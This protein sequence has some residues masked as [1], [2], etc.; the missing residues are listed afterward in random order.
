[1][2]RIA[3]ISTLL[4]L[5]L[6]GIWLLARPGQP[7]PETGGRQ[8]NLRRAFGPVASTGESGARQQP[9][10]PPPAFEPAEPVLVDFRAAPDPEA[11][12]FDSQYDLWLRGEIDLDREVSRISEVEM[13]ERR[14]ASLARRPDAGVQ[15]SSSA[16][17]LLPPAP[18]TH[19]PALNASVSP[20]VPPDP[21]MAAGPNHL[22]VAVNVYIAIYDKTGNELFRMPPAAL[23]QQQPCTTN[24]ALFDPNVLYDEEAGRWILAYAAGPVTSTGGYCML[25]STSGDPLGTWYSY[26]FRT[27]SSDGWLDFPHAG[28]GDNHIFMAGNIFF[29]TIAFIESRLYAFPKAQ[30]YGGQTVNWTGRGFGG[31]EATDNFFAPQPLKLH[32]AAQGDWP[33]FGN[34]HYFLVDDSQWNFGQYLLRYALVRWNPVTAALTVVNTLNF[35]AGGSHILVPQAGGDPVEAN[36]IRPLDFEFGDGYGWAAMTVGCNPGSGTVNCVRWAQ[37]NLSNGQPGPAAS[38]LFASNGE[39]RFFPALAVNH[40]G[41]MV[42]GYSKGSASTWPG[43]WYTGRGADDS[44]GFLRSEQLLKAGEKAYSSFENIDP[45]EARRWGDYT[46][47]TVDPDGLRFWYVGEYPTSSSANTN[48][49]TYVGSFLMS[50]NLGCNRPVLDEVLFLPAVKQ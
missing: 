4:A 16:D 44:A 8:E 1:M 14:E 47:M 37:I 50:T 46:G 45:G 42:V 41:D 32:G 27:N 22:L 24:S 17:T 18:Q 29:S 2:R 5:L 6:L 13:A 25:V 35:G 36:D 34:E 33:S 15:L 7:A 28:V 3:Q 9:D 26:F 49:G 23:F 43:L 11:V 40:C 21:E 20:Y 12:A 48:W 30:L 31:D 38:G 10:G 39:H 19:F